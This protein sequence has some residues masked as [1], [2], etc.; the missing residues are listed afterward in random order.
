MVATT[1][2][3]PTRAAPGLLGQYRCLL[4]SDEAEYRHDR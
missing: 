1:W 4:E 2:D 3:A